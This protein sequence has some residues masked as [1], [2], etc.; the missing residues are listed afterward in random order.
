MYKWFKLHR[1]EDG[2][3]L[4]EFALVLP[5]LMIILLGIIEF[6][7][8]FNAKITLNSAAREGARIYAITNDVDQVDSAV[9]KAASHLSPI[10]SG[11]IVKTS[12]ELSVGSE[13]MMAKVTITKDVYFLT[14]FFNFILPNKISMVSTAE[15]RVEYE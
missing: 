15:M 9:N 1:K 7:F 11:S 14:N 8:M 13:I 5:I 2:Q 6:G 3:G 10:P 4:V 12:G